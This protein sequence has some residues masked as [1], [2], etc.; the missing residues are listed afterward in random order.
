MIAPN[1][2]L[3]NIYTFTSTFNSK[4]FQIDKTL[5]NVA[6]DIDSDITRKR[7][8]FSGSKSSRS[9]SIVLKASSIP[10]YKR[11][12]INNDLPNE[13]FVN[14]IDSSQL[15]Y[16]D[17]NGAGNLVRKVTDIGLIRNQQHVQCEDTAPKNTFTT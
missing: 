15:S 16:K 7:S 9:T 14:P 17:D 5:A 13:K 4:L 2:E 10:Y 3:A 1:S 12:E 11:M 6:M 8:I